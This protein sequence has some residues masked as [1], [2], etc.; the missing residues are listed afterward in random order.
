MIG[1]QNVLC[2]DQL[3]KNKLITYLEKSNFAQLRVSHI[4]NSYADTNEYALFM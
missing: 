2:I 1:Q 3:P 4:L